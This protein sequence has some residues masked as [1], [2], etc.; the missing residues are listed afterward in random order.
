MDEDRDQDAWGM[1]TCSPWAIVV[2]VIMLIMGILSMGCVEDTVKYDGSPGIYP[3]C[4][5]DWFDIYYNEIWGV[6]YRGPR[7]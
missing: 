4:K 3:P 7:K 1:A 6:Q 5:T 2:F